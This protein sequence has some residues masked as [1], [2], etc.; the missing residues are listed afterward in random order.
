M[1]VLDLV[2][3][4]IASIDKIEI[5]QRFTDYSIDRKMRR[6]TDEI[7]N[8]LEIER[9]RVNE[10]DRKFEG[11]TIIVYHKGSHGERRS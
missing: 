9:R 10:R 3:F 5:S 11:N 7:E 4:F 6:K 1:R 2:Y 8:C